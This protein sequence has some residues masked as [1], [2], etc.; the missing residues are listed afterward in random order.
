MPL[1]EVG[2][3]SDQT[4]HSG[5]DPPAR[6]SSGVVRAAPLLVIE[7]VDAN[8]ND[9][10]I[11][12]CT[13]TPDALP[14]PRLVTTISKFGG[15]VPGVNEP[16]PQSGVIVTASWATSLLHPERIS[17]IGPTTERATSSASRD[18]SFRTRL[19]RETVRPWLRCEAARAV[20]AVGM[21]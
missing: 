2:D 10:G 21:R 20:A 14:G 11:T 6:A 16:L 19:K 15:V 9:A 18:V 5:L 3:D 8:W 1:G 13:T 12:A 7:F 17:A 4:P